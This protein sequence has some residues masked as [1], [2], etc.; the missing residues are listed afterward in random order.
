MGRSPDEYVEAEVVG[1]LMFFD[2]PTQRPPT[3]ALAS[4]IFQ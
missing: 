1:W 4:E 3:A 2:H